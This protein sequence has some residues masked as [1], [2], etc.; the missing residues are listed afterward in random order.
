VRLNLHMQMTRNVS[1]LE[2]IVLKN[3]QHF[4]AL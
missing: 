4:N 3:V 2:S 1:P